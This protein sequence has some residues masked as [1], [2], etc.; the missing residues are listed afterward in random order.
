MATITSADIKR[1]R[2]ITGAGMSDVKA[3]LVAADGDHQHAIDALRM[4]G[5]AKALERG[6]GRTASNG[7]VASAGGAL[8]ELACETDFVAKNERFQQLANEIVAH[9]A[10]T[11]IGDTPRLLQEKLTDGATIEQ[12]I[13]ALSAAIREKLELRRVVVMSG[14]VA[15]Y[16]HRRASDLPPQ[17]GVLVEFTGDDVDAARGAAMQVASLG[18]QYVSHEEVP[19]DAVA[20]ERE[21]AEATAKEEGKPEAVRSKIV[22]GRVQGFFKEVVLLE[23]TSVRDSKQ[24]V[25]A[26]LNAAGVTVTRFA[27]FEVGRA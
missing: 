26:M 12:S 16:L 20:K 10:A 2:E 15:T 11:S 13:V 23:Q 25:K 27:R 9:A 18:A 14:K 6:A 8:I 3:A 5:E 22:E 4:K 1:V 7:I 19:A 24:S 17:I 21:I